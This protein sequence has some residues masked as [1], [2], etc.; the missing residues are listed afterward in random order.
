MAPVPKS[1]S[2]QPVWIA[3]SVIGSVIFMAI[4]PF[5]ATAIWI[6]CRDLWWMMATNRSRYL[7]AEELRKEWNK[8]AWTEQRRQDIVVCAMRDL[9]EKEGKPEKKWF[10]F[11]ELAQRTYF[12]ARKYLPHPAIYV[13]RGRLWERVKY[14]LFG[15]GY[16]K[17]PWHIDMNEWNEAMARARGEI[18]IHIEEFAAVFTL[19]PPPYALV[20]GNL[21][22]H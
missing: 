5:L 12:P 8:A 18:D 15:I 1:S 3:V 9:I 10:L 11:L 6:F 2:P 13:L 14:Q 21:L 19:S 4:L 20:A 17:E 22:E 7:E 16:F